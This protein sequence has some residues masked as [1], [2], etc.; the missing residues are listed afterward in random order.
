MLNE[1]LVIKHGAFGDFIMAEGAFR[2]IRTY[3]KNTKITLL[4]STPF[5]AL[6]EQSKYFDVVKIDD[7]KS[8]WHLCTLFKL[9]KLFKKPYNQI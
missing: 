9:R 4:T 5:K 3:H 7:R 8:F 6:A 2:A 1:I